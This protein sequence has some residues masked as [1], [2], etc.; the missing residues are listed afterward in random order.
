[1]VSLFGDDEPLGAEDCHRYGGH[2]EALRYERGLIY[3]DDEDGQ[4]TGRDWRLL[5]RT[6]YHRNGG[7]YCEPRGKS[8]RCILPRHRILLCVGELSVSYYTLRLLRSPVR[9]EL[10]LYDYDSIAEQFQKILAAVFEADL[11][12]VADRVAFGRVFV[13]A[14]DLT[15]AEEPQ[16]ILPDEI[17]GAAETQ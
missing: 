3:S 5:V 6:P 7:N 1:M 13:V 8:E 17:L 2:I 12:K 10:L 4:Q 11:E 15:V 16:M 9:N 14:A